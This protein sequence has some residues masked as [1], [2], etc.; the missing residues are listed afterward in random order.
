MLKWLFLIS[1]AVLFSAVLWANVAGSAHDFSDDGWSNGQICLPC[2]TPHNADQTVLDAPLWNHAVTTATFTVYTSPTMVTTAQEPRGI[3][4]L[5]L[6]CHDGTVALDSF[7]GATGSVPIDPAYNVGT[8]LSDDHPISIYWQHQNDLRNG[9]CIGCHNP[10]PTDFNPIL[11]LFDRYIECA[12]C[13][14]VHNKDNFP[15]LLRKSQ[16]NSELCFHCH[17]K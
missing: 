11:P 4:K 15:S 8:D 2:H 16:V 12:S 3:S 5:C 9:T 10:N 13:H 1:I 17:G 14:D 7:G 6:S